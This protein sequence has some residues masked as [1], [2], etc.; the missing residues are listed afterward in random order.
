MV[1]LRLA[2]DG[3]DVVLTYESNAERAAEVVE[4]I[5]ATGRRALAVQADS[6]D[7][8]ALTAS[9]DRAAWDAL[10]GSTSWSTTRGPSSS[11]RWKTWARPRPTPARWR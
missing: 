2:E 9:V 3:A 7:A 5:K 1:A 10:V 6:A 11:A 4:R 8:E